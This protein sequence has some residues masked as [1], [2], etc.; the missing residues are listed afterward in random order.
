MSLTSK[1]Q[2]IKHE[3]LAKE[4]SVS[5]RSIRDALKVLQARGLIT[6][7]RKKIESTESTITFH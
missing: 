2:T 5:Q 3:V 4:I 7:R 6:C 1:T